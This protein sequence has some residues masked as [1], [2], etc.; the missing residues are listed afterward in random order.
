MSSRETRLG[1]LR[2]VLLLQEHGVH[3]PSKAVTDNVS[4]R[5][6]QPVNQPHTVSP[7]C[8]WFSDQGLCPRFHFC[9]WLL[10]AVPAATDVKL[11]C[12]AVLTV[13]CLVTPPRYANNRR[14]YPKMHGKIQ[15]ANN[16]SGFTEF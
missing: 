3:P 14:G 13:A 12:T 10:C 7:L 6:Q 4:S 15:T 16:L 5:Q 9:L 1:N 2:G 8:V 11:G